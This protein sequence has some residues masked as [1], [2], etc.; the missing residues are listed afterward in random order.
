MAEPTQRAW[1]IEWGKPG[2]FEAV[3]HPLTYI[4]FFSI[5]RPQWTERQIAAGKSI[6]RAVTGNPY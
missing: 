6:A 5:P 4:P 3:C 2:I 1:V